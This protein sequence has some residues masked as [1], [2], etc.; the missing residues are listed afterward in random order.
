MAERGMK[1]PLSAAMRSHR[2]AWKDDDQSFVVFIK[3][4]TIYKNTLRQ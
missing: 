4:G 2:G 3:D 1:A